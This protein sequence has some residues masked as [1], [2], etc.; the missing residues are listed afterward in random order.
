MERGASTGVLRPHQPDV[1]ASPPGRMCG[2]AYEP[3]RHLRAQKREEQ[4]LA[5]RQ[6]ARVVRHGAGRGIAEVDEP[7]QRPQ[8]THRLLVKADA[9][10]VLSKALRRQR[11][12]GGTPVEGAPARGDAGRHARCAVEYEA[13]RGEE[14]DEVEE[15]EAAWLAG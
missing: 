15:R 7:C 2:G 4:F 12:S 1:G 10:G 13:A 8:R 11:A 6:T 14:I 9:F 5:A 3:S